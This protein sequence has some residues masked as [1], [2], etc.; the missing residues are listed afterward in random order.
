MLTMPAKDDYG[1]FIMSALITL[2]DVSFSIDDKN[3]LQSVDLSIDEQEIVTIV[4][5]NGA[6]KSTLLSLA[7]QL[8]KPTSGQVKQRQNLRLAYVPQSINRDPTMPVSVMDFLRLAKSVPSKQAIQAILQ[9]LGLSQLSKT[10][11]NHLS[12]GELRRVLFARALLNKP[13]LLVLDEPTAGVDV[14]GQEQFYE[15]LNELRERYQ[16]AILMVSHD[17]H[18][19]MSST[20]RVICLNQHICCQGQPAHVLHDPHYQALFGQ[21]KQEAEQEPKLAFYEHHHDHEH[22]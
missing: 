15:Q 11:I 18:L 17:L 5:P 10:L 22:N 6:G 1:D 8:R 16:F 7:L 2:S 9:E 21:L 4:G 19:V 3:I 12:G 14:I 13:E 20:D